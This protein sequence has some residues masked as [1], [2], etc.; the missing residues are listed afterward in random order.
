MPHTLI[1]C[2]TI[3]TMDPTR[4]IIR[5]GALLVGDNRIERVLTREERDRM[6]PFDGARVDA[7]PMTAIPGFV[8]THVHLCQT[9]FRGLAD[10]LELLDWLKQRIWP[11]EAAHTPASLA[12]AAR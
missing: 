7:G 9:L 1:T 10:D 2:G 4:R 6:G 5:D 3:V 12:A 8:Q 11:M